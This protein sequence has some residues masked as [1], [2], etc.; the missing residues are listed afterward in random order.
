MR[1]YIFISI[2]IFAILSSWVLI[3][4]LNFFVPENWPQPVYDFKQNKLTKEKIELGR[5][6]FYD[7]ILSKNNKISCAS[8]HSSYGAFAHVD[9]ALSHG[10]YDS[11]GTRNVPGLINLAWQPAFRWDGGIDNL[12][13]FSIMPITH[14]K[15]MGE[16]MSSVVSKL[17]QSSF[18]KNLFFHSFQDSVITKEKLLKSLSQFLLTLVSYNSKYDSVMRKQAS[19]TKQESNGYQIFKSYC[20]VCHQEPLFTNFSYQNNGLPIDSALNDYG[21]FL[22]TQN[23]KDSFL[24]KVPT[25]RN[26]EYSFPYMHDG[27][28]KKLSEVIKHYTSGIVSTSTLS[29]SLQKKISLTTNEKIDLIAFLLTLSDRTFVFNPDFQFPKQLLTH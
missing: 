26:I 15:E 16:Q 18:Y 10:I 4:D 28:F 13:E 27:R 9:H 17:N 19:F 14:P 1:K 21:R 8:C 11:I 7:P 6:L 29:L 25:L 22:V 12:D 23:P 2:V 24:F 20:N 5:I 3:E